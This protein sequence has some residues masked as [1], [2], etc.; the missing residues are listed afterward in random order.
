MYVKNINNDKYPVIYKNAVLC[1]GSIIL[2]NVE[3][4]ENCTI[5]ANSLVLKDCLANG[6][7]VGNPTKRIN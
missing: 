1:T 7:Y 6:I 5:G 3:I 4:G 2:G